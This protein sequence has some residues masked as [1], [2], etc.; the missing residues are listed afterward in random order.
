[1]DII[2]HIEE[3]PKG[4]PWPPQTT[5]AILM[6]IAYQT[7]DL[8]TAQELMAVIEN[9]VPAAP[10]NIE[11]MTGPARGSEFLWYA[12]TR[13]TSITVKFRLFLECWAQVERGD[14]LNGIRRRF[15]KTL[16]WLFDLPEA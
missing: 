15:V 14:G 12:W 8:S 7:A 3:L 9:Y 11:M 2:R 6:D 4:Q 10:E 16:I 1:M 13:T 5:L